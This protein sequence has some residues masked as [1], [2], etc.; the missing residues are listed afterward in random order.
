M[1]EEDDDYS[2]RRLL[3]AIGVTGTLGAVGGAATGAYLTDWEP[4]SGNLIGTGELTLELATD[5]ATDVTSLESFSDDD[6]RTDA[7]I[8]VGFSDIEAGDTGVLR[9]GHRLGEDLGR[10]WMRA[11]SS[12]GTDLGSHIDVELL[13]R[14]TCDDGESTQLY[15]GTLDEL[16]AAYADGG[17]LT[18]SCVNGRW[19]LDLKWT[20]QTDAPADLSEESLSCSFDF[21]AVQCRHS[22]T[23]DNPWNETN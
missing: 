8:D 17:L 19:C 1:S 12:T 9:V 11:T 5:Q 18:D 2:R 7:T 20:F 22:Q 23:D 10:I 13:Q 21:I 3:Q 15:L 4:F 6:F 16:M 14:P